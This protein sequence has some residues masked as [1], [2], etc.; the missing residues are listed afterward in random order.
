MLEPDL[1]DLDGVRPRRLLERRV[2]LDRDAAEDDVQVTARLDQRFVEFGAD[3]LR[4]R[5][6]PLLGRRPGVD[7][8]RVHGEV[9]DRRAVARAVDEH[10]E[11]GDGELE[12]AAE[13]DE[14]DARGVRP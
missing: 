3:R 10:G 2:G 5:I 7:L 12:A 1:D 14:A 8:Q 11:V 6:H 9:D 13:P 4:R